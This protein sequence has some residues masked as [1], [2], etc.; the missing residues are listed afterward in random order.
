MKLLLQVDSTAR[1]LTVRESWNRMAAE[2]GVISQILVSHHTPEVADVSWWLLKSTCGAY[3]AVLTV[4]A[5]PCSALYSTEVSM[6]DNTAV[7]PAPAQLSNNTC[8]AHKSGASNQEPTAVS[9][10]TT[11]AFFRGNGTNVIKIAPETAIKLTCNDRLKRM[12]CK[13]VEEITPLQRM[14]SG[15][16]A[17]AVAQVRGSSLL[18]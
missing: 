9:A 11:S 16:L 7:R 13:D 18:L 8:P 6:H 17:G 5:M 1:G 2:G 10:G 14:L 3:F 4:L 15:A 12:V